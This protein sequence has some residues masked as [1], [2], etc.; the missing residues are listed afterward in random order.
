MRSLLV[1]AVIA[2][3]SDGNYLFA[4]QA[5]PKSD[6]SAHE[7]VASLDAKLRLEA[8]RVETGYLSKLFE[9]I[10]DHDSKK[11]LVISEAQAELAGKLAQLMRDL[12]RAWLVRDLEKDPPPAKTE[13]AAR[14]AA[15]E[16]FRE[17]V[18]THARQSS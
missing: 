12:I 4:Q 5:S 3:F 14:L 7:S 2:V 11:L 8:S 10:I 1:A 6:G 17:S 15:A 18:A 9:S 16:E 13:L